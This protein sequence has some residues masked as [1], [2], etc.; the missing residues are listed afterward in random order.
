MIKRAAVQERNYSFGVCLG[1]FKKQCSS[2]GNCES[3]VYFA[4]H[5]IFNRWTLLGQKQQEDL[6]SKESQNPRIIWVRRDFCRSSGSAPLKCAGGS[7]T[8]LVG[9]E[10][11]PRL[12]LKVSREGTSTTSLDSSL[13]GFSAFTVKNFFL[14]TSL[15]L[16]IKQKTG[17]KTKE[18]SPLLYHPTS[19][20]THASIQGMSN[21]ITAS[22]LEKVLFSGQK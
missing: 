4:F 11:C 22:L 9:S 3:V 8:L 5:D 14:R 13:H 17:K 20:T 1:E 18:R 15:C 7:S 6:K 21:K 16:N 2:S 10:L 19:V 12:T